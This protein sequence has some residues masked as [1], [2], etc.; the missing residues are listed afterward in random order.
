LGESLEIF[1]FKFIK[2]RA[3]SLQD[4]PRRYEKKGR[5]VMKRKAAALSKKGK[6]ARFYLFNLDSP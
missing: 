1:G 3:F 5:G 2:D 6:A 4:G